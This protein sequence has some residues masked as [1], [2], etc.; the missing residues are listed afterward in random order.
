LLGTEKTLSELPEKLN[1]CV[2]KSVDV[3]K[4]ES[5]W[6]TTGEQLLPNKTLLA[7]KPGF[8]SAVSY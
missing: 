5:S 2:E 3:E 4:P 8:S 1:V 7:R 6:G